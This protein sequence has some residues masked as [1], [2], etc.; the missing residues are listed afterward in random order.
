MK[1]TDVDV[2]TVVVPTI[3]GRVH[4]LSFGK[5]GWDEVPK[6]I[7]RVN[8]DEGLCGLGETRRGCPLEDVEAGGRRLEGKDPLKLSLQNIFSEV[9]P[10]R[11]KSQ[12]TR[13]WEG[14]G[15]WPGGPAGS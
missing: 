13:S 2:W 6:H 3:P 14:P 7:I 4:S 15:G 9:A 10:H 8:T 11:P 5:A 1:I 12:G